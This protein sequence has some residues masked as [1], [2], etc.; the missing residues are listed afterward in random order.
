MRCRGLDSWSIALLAVGILWVAPSSVVA[1]TNDQTTNINQAGIAIDADGVL[2]LKS[3]GDPGGQLM[4]ERIASAKSTLGPKLASFSKMRK[5]SLN[6]LEQAIRDHQDTLTDEM[7]CLAGLQRVRYVFCYPD[8]KDIVL[9]GPAEGWAADA[10]GRIVGISTGRPV[11]QVQDLVVALRA[12]PPSGDKTSLIGCS[13]DST[14]EGQVAMRQFISGIHLSGP[15][16]AQQVR[17]IADGLRNSLGLQNVTINGISPKS[18]Y[19][20]VLVEAD[21]R[22]KL[23]GI[24]L[25]APPIRMASYVDHANPSEI[26]RNA[27]QR[28]FF[29]PDYQCVRESEDM[30]AMELVGDG[31]KLVGEDEMVMGNGQRRAATGRKNKASQAFTTAFT[32]K[33]PELAERSPV[34]AELRNLVD[35]AIA[36]AYIQEQGFF[37][38]TGWKMPFFGSEQEFPVEVYSIPKT[39][40]SAVNAIW[41]GRTLTT[42]IGGGVTIDPTEA[43]KSDNLLSDKKGT[44]AK[45]RES[46]K[47]NL[48][49]GQW[50]WD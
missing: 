31:V 18:H 12:F 22:M 1:Q 39:V 11:V 7:R 44:V 3:F 24:G 17:F 4:R 5:I 23:I 45:A 41:K 9:A 38:K 13:I 50:W 16:S 46:V 26:G 40:E 10:S 28:W 37:E 2:R 47:L 20:Q 42:P 25:E 32:K 19:A 15:P 27:M 49:K 6:R 21:Y 34:Y 48:P 29:V 43:L 8:S 36:A 35:L 30:L 33:Y 14:P